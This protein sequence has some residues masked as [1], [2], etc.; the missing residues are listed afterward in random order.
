MLKIGVTSC[1]FYPDVERLV[2]GK[3][4]LCYLEKDMANYLSRPDVMPILIP[5]LTDEDLEPFLAEMDGFVLQGGTDVAPES[6]GEA[7]IVEGKW[8]GDR[9][10]DEYE[11]KI[12]DY[13]IKEDK[14]LLGICRGLQ[15]MNVY[16]GGTLYQDIATQRPDALKQRDAEEY[17]QVN[18]TIE[19]VPG[20]LLDELHGKEPSKRVNSVHH[21]AIKGLGKNLEVMAI[22][23]EDDI[24]EA[25]MWNGAE[26]GKVMAV[27]WHPEF[28]WN[29]KG[30]PGLIDAAPVYEKFLSFCKGN[31]KG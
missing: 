30:S 6:Y 14:P 29:F 15:V 4:S 3:K 18:H 2:F 20:S 5:D 12:V 11:L 7:P 9:Y 31:V 1:F 19:F 22:S 25:F 24:I 28:F 16:F 8:L 13:A 26:E 10:R 21:Q 27:Q 17:D 23:P